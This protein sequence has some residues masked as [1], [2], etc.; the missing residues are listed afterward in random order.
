MYGDQ[1][2]ENNCWLPWCTPGNSVV[3]ECLGYTDNFSK[4]YP[5]Q[6]ECTHKGTGNI[7]SHTGACWK[8]S[9]TISVFYNVY[10]AA[11]VRFPDLP[12]WSPS[13]NS[14][15]CRRRLSLFLFCLALWQNWSS[16]SRNIVE[17]WSFPLK[18][19]LLL[20]YR[21]PYFHS[22]V[23]VTSPTYIIHINFFLF[24]A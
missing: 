19:C 23:D 21:S 1:W 14:G 2:C 18:H 15:F 17:S 12:R 24:I 10:L 4:S 11:F 7:L 5:A 9:P 20:H 13:W 22:N 3:F 6:S 8:E 16:F